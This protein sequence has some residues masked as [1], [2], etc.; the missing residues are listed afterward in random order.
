MFVTIGSINISNY[1]VIENNAQN[2]LREIIDKGPRP[3]EGPGSPGGA[4]NKLKQEHYFV[5]SFN[6]DGSIKETDNRQMFILTKGE[7][8]ELAT[9]VYNNELS[10]GKY[11]SFRYSKITKNDGI[12]YVGFVDMKERLDSFNNFLLVSSLVSLGAYIVLIGL[13][14]IA[15]R[16]AFKSSEEAYKKQKRFITNA[17]HELKTPI[18]IISADLDLI[19]M[20]NGK[21]EWSD[22]IRDQLK[23]LTE[24]TNQLVTLSKLEED[25]PTRFPFD[26]FSV[27]EVCG[28]VIES[29]S[30]L[31]KKG[32]IRFSYNI[33]GKFTMYGNKNLIDE[34]IRL[35]LDNSLKYTG[36]DNKSSYFTVSENAKGKIEFR[37]SNTIDKDDEVDIK[38]IMER[39]YRSPSN[40]KEGSGV[41]LSIAQEIINLHKGKIAAEKNASTINFTISFN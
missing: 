9:K 15:S 41:G 28:N 26:D 25:D 36:G 32:N 12:T 8:E 3:D 24:M 13:I 39:F 34:L 23:R 6:S 21:N 30:P 17:S 18:T 35:F 37:F 33:T 4:P 27:N 14:I 5:V 19:E 20:D 40:K 31:F 2:S 7:C 16:I 1:V 38:Q 29:F 10:G 11:E 22:S